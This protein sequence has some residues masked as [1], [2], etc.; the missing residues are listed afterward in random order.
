MAKKNI[1]RQRLS[2]LRDLLSDTF[3]SG[4]GAH[5]DF[6]LSYTAGDFVIEIYPPSSLTHHM[7]QILVLSFDHDKQVLERTAVHYMPSSSSEGHLFEWIYT[8][9]PLLAFGA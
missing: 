2:R 5:T 4:G 9:I 3:T 6:G 7:F 1:Y 8:H